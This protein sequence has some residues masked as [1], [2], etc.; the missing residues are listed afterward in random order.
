MTAVAPR[1]CFVGIRF[2]VIPLM[3]ASGVASENQKVIRT[4]VFGGMIEATFLS[5]AVV[6]TLVER[7]GRKR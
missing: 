1:F 6:Q 3:V 7:A 2:G 5:L 4:S